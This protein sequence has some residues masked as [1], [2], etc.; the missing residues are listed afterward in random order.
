MRLASILMA[1][2][3]ASCVD[4]E[5]TDSPDGKGDSPNGSGGG[6]G[7]AANL[8]SGIDPSPKDHDL[9]LGVV[10]VSFVVAFAPLGIVRK[11][12]RDCSAA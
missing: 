4:T 9:E 8:G 1:L 7:S 3:L 6:S 12:R 11:R 5:D 10:A 2:L